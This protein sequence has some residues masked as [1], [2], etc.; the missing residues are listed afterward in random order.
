MSTLDRFTEGKKY[1]FKDGTTVISILAVGEEWTI[2]KNHSTGSEL[3]V[4]HREAKF[5]KEYAPPKPLTFADL[6][7][8]EKF[9]FGDNSTDLALK[10]R[11]LIG[12]IGYVYLE[13]AR[14][15]GC[16][17]SNTPVRRA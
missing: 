10:T 9:Y 16:D 15:W 2:A 17:Q 1:K 6:K 4:P 12:E 3:P 5:Y 13:E 7:V 14:Y 8:G 11:T